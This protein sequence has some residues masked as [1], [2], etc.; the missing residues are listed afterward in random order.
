MI[1]SARD[2]NEIKKVLDKPDAMPEN[3]N[4][5]YEMRNAKCEIRNTK[6]EMLGKYEHKCK[7]CK[8]RW[9]GNVED[10]RRCRVCGT[11]LWDTDYTIQDA[12][13]RGG[14]PREVVGPKFTPP[15]RSQNPVSTT[16][17]AKISADRDDLFPMDEVL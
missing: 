3:R 1:L 5:K 9:F 17:T 13:M 11:R 12:A 2:D 7:R 16:R 6:C 4:T 15:A 8:S 10:P 14:R